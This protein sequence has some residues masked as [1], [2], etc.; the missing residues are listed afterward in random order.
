MEGLDEQLKKAYE[1]L[2][3]VNANMWEQERDKFI[4]K[5]DNKNLVS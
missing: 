5:F 4:S 1:E 2:Q 3:K